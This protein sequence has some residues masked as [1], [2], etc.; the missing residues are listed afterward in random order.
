M[1]T[2]PVCKAPLRTIR[3][4]EGIYFLCDQ[5]GG[6]AATV[7]HI[8]RVCG[9][10]FATQILRRINQATGVAVRNCP[11][12]QRPM[13]QFEITD[14][15]LTLDACKPC[16]LV[17]FDPSEFEA[18][19]EGVV[20]TVDELDLRGRQALAEYQVK[21]IAEQALAQDPT[22]DENWKWL[23][24]FLGL[25]VELDA[26]TLKCRPWATWALG[27]LIVL[28]SVAGFFH[29]DEAVHRFGLIPAQPWRYGGF[30]W[31]SSFFLHGGLWHLLGNLYFLL[32]VGDNVEDY[33]GRWRYILLVVLATVG[34]DAL[35]TMVAAHSTEPS[36]GASGGISGLLAFY[37]LEFPRARLGFLLRYFWQF[38]WI[39]MPAWVAFGLWILLQIFGVYTQLAGFSHVSALAHLGGVG[40]GM[41]F[42]LIWGR[43]ARKE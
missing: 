36:I 29:L 30:T 26:T 19:P 38:S 17:W 8:R 6:R 31:I 28:V 33:L 42:W 35:H 21:Q 23:P 25:P 22:P 14:P 13:K 5:C 34:G 40:V 32:L 27:A 39:Q 10:R 4:R 3:Q 2:C 18:I 12:C 41:V 1:P 7:P 20:E 37:A 11:F 15:P 9:D 43:K 24:A 16:T